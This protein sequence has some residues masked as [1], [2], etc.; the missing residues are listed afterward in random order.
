MKA[1]LGGCSAEEADRCHFAIRV[2]SEMADE[3]KYLG[4]APHRFSTWYT[5][6]SAIAR[7]LNSTAANPAE[8]LAHLLT[9]IA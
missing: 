5:E 2:P 9:Q 8:T 1:K 7:S 6:C 3:A 4:I